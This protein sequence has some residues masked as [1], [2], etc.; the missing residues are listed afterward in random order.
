[1]AQ[2]GYTALIKASGYGHSSIVELLLGDGADVEAKTD[3]VCHAFTAGMK[4]E[5]A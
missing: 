4:F 3:Q 1:L 2:R 5:H